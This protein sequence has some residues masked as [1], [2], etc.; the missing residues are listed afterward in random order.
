MH[1]QADGQII[2]V[3]SL[4]DWLVIGAEGRNEL[5]PIRWIKHGQLQVFFFSEYVIMYTEFS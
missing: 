5:S 2:V 4:F 1:Q 3:T